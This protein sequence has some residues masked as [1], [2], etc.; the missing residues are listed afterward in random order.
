MDQ[1][2]SCQ[3]SF[4]LGQPC[5]S[6]SLPAVLCC[7]PAPCNP[8]ITGQLQSVNCIW[9][10]PFKSGL[11]EV[12]I[13]LNVSQAFLPEWKGVGRAPSP[14]S[15]HPAGG[16]PLAQHCS[17]L[18]HSTLSTSNTSPLPV[19]VFLSLC[20]GWGGWGPMTCHPAL[21]QPGPPSAK[22]LWKLCSCWLQ[23]EGVY[24][25]CFPT[26]PLG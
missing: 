2:W 20:L 11:K 22:G 25:T 7:S 9:L 13:W 16:D 17:V 24:R 5:P 19:P 18:L 10:G 15:P 21:L 1:R 8:H 26:I 23:G 12:M 14:V 3:V 6:C 4:L